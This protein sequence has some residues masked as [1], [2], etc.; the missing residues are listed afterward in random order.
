M[1]NPDGEFDDDF[2]DFGEDYDQ[3]PL[4]SNAETIEPAN[5]KPHRHP[6]PG[7]RRPAQDR[8]HPG[9]TS[10]TGGNRRSPPGLV[11]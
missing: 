2:D 5:A 11:F 7:A 1:I 9:A 4:A 8:G 3:Q 10:I 6:T